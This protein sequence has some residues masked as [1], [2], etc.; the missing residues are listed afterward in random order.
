MHDY[1]SKGNTVYLKII[2][3]LLVILAHIRN[4]IDSLNSTYLGSVLTTLGYLSV[5]MFMFL[6]GY[7]IEMQYK[8]RGEQYIESFLRKRICPFFVINSVSVIFYAMFKTQFLNMRLSAKTFIQSFLFGDTVM[9]YGWYLQAIIFLY[10]IFYISH[11]FGKNYNWKLAGVGIGVVMYVILA[12][13]TSSVPRLYCQSLLGFVIGLLYAQKKDVIDKRLEQGKKQWIVLF[14]V[15]IGF[16]ITYIVGGLHI[17]SVYIWYPM[18]ILSAGLFVLCVV[19]LVKVLS[20]RLRPN[21]TIGNIVL[22]IYIV[23]EIAISILR[24]DYL[25]IASDMLYIII[26]YVATIIIAVVVHPLFLLINKVFAR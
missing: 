10:L 7:G 11:R 8:I 1:L 25:W 4:S 3:A 20:I 15:C 2:F 14:G 23:Q 18:R 22:E 13:L 12:Y 24:S 16:F 17:G 26:A 6:S 19:F 9:S 21:E 5:A